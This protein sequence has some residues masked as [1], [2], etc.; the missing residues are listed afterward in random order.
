MSLHLKVNHNTQLKPQFT[1]RHSCG[2]SDSYSTETFWRGEL[3]LTRQR[4]EKSEDVRRKEK[5]VQVEKAMLLGDIPCWQQLSGNGSKNISHVYVWPACQSWDK[6]WQRDGDSE[7]SLSLSHPEC[8]AAHSFSALGSLHQK[9]TTWVT[10]S[11]QHRQRT[12]SLS[13]I[14]MLFASLYTCGHFI[15]Y[16]L[17]A[18]GWTSFSLQN[19]F[20][21]SWSR[22]NKTFSQMLVHM[23]TTV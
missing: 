15:S 18:P 3:K 2:S 14:W 12:H 23:D 13:E 17:I 11:V 6:E 5:C 9:A 8:E 1:L 21:F 16:T 20:H 7:I 4:T 19:H 22:L 10:I